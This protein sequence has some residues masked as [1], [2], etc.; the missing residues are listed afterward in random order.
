MESLR[1]PGLMETA[2]KANLIDKERA[3]IA[4]DNRCV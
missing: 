2:E 4:K 3:K 1:A